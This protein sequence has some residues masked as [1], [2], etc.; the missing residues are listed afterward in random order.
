TAI[1]ISTSSIIGT[2][3]VKID[4]AF[5]GSESAECLKTGGINIRFTGWIFQDFAC[6]KDRT[7]IG[8]SGMLAI[9]LIIAIELIGIKI[10]Q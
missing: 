10:G 8:E 1:Y 2:L 6:P 7:S 3:T 4:A 5:I 9:P